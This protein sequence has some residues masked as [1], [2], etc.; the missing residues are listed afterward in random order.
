MK[1]L[2]VDICTTVEELAVFVNSL[3]SDSILGGVSGT[4][5]VVTL[6]TA[7]TSA[8]GA[9]KMLL[10]NRLAARVAVE[11]VLQQMAGMPGAT[12]LLRN[13]E[14]QFNDD[15]GVR[16]GWLSPPLTILARIYKK[17]VN[18]LPNSLLP[19]IG[20]QYLPKYED[21][22]VDLSAS[23]LNRE[24]R[25]AVEHLADKLLLLSKPRNSWQ[26]LNTVEPSSD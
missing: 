21:N 25:Q 23:E 17:T 20:K 9:E 18:A 12:P 15:H 4:N 8:P 24:Q 2:A 11:V 26:G 10:R 14:E 1:E 7:D 6:Y 5:G 19:S 16:A 3:S 22:G 13:V